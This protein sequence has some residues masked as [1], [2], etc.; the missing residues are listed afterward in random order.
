MPAALPKLKLWSLCDLRPAED[1][2]CRVRPQGLKA[3]KDSIQKF[4]VDRDL[5]RWTL[6]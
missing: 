4:W 1:N 3:L 2:P 5:A 6:Q